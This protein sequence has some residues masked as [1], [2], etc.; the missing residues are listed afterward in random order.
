MND[1]HLGDALNLLVGAE[2]DYASRLDGYWE[3]W[4]RGLGAAT[5]RPPA[6]IP[7]TVLDRCDYLDKFPHLAT[8]LATPVVQGRGEHDCLANPA[9]CY[10]VYPAFE[11][12]RL[13]EPVL[14]TLAAPCFRRESRYARYERQW[15]FTMREVVCIGSAAEVVAF[16]ESAAAEV[17][18]IAAGLGIAG[19]FEDASDPFFAAPDARSAGLMQRLARLKREWVIPGG[20]AIASLNCHQRFFADRF[21]I[22]RDGEVAF[23]GCV[24]F[25]LERWLLALRQR[26]GTSVNSWPQ[27][28][29]L[30]WAA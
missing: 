11:G 8:F 13:S 16:L 28:E 21:E 29:D 30:S 9:A 24:A 3:R 7:R 22:R 1:A 27:P 26:Y 23:S 25:G 2:A 5:M 20:T 14:V 18:R 15:G 17:G 6:C 10:H 4:A 19:R 12:A